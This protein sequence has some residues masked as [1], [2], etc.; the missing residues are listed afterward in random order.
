MTI[1]NT[2]TLGLALPVTGTEAGVWGD[3]VNAGITTFLEG[4]ITGT[5]NITVTTTDITLAVTNYSSGTPVLTSTSAQYPI[6]NC[7]GAMTGNRSINLPNLSKIYYIIN[8]TTGGFTLTFR[9]V[10]GPTAG[11]VTLQ[12]SRILIAWNGSD[13]V[14]IA[15]QNGQLSP[16]TLQGI[17][18]TTS[19]DSANAGSVGEVIT[20]TA[21]SVVIPTATVTNVTSMVITPGDWDV[22]GT[23]SLHQPLGG[24]YNSIDSG[25]SFVSATIPPAPY[26][27][28]IAPTSLAAF[29]YLSF[30]T[31]T[32]RVNV[33]AP[34]TIYLPCRT[35]Y[36]VGTVVADGEILARRMR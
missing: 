35:T 13:F 20:V 16:N 8:N 28:Q 18:G 7:T 14:N 19:A 24:N 26:S 17:I 5:Q 33:S 1:N 27:L 2:S 11:V 15:N 10:T 4:S 32:R 30:P 36:S 21:A 31:Y 3:A 9:G 22:R 29:T 34:T 6:L 23:I 25:L 12:G